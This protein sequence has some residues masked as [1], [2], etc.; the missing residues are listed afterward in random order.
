MTSTVSAQNDHEVPEL[1]EGAWYRIA[2]D[3]ESD[4][5]LGDGDGYAGGTWYYYPD[6]NES[7]LGT[8]RQWY[9]NGPYDPN[10]KGYLEYVVYIKSVDTTRNDIRRNPFQ[11]VHAPM[12][13]SGQEAST[14]AVRRQ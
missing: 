10:R 2:L 3:Q 7:E 13:G 11:L 5:I 1:Y 8:W 14:A 12:V 9:Y 4:Y 6:A